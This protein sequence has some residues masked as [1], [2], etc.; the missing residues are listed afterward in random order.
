MEQVERLARMLG[1][2]PFEAG[3]Q[4]PVAPPLS[5]WDTRDEVIVAV[6]MPGVSK[7]GLHVECRGRLVWITGQ[8]RGV[9][10]DA[11]LI[12]SEH[13]LAPY[14]RIVPL[15]EGTTAADVD[16]QITD[17]LLELRIRRKVLPQ[18]A[19]DIPVR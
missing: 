7:E 2:S 17:G 11:R 8:P 19:R 3:R 18:E 9:R 16:A 13:L 15:P 6:E 12:V 1:G 5:V 14:Q 10:N 4:Q